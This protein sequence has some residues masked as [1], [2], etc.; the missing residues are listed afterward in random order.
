MTT[1]ATYKLDSQ[2]NFI[3]LTIKGHSGFE[4]KGKDIVCAGISAITNGTL[5][6]LQTHYG[7]DCQ[8]SY[9]PLPPAKSRVL[10]SYSQVRE[11]RDFVE[12]YDKT[13]GGAGEP[14]IIISSIKKNS[15]I[16]LCL[17]L[18]IFQLKNIANY[19]PRY[20]EISPEE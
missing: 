18:M 4:K 16:H 19:Y 8:I 20:L 13:F 3:Y 15:P 10:R 5:N 14:S 7:D 6:F 9:S 2:G 11:A 1:E 17:Q 12:T